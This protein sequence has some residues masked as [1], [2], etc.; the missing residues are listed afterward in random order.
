MVNDITVNKF[1][2]HTHLHISQVLKI[3]RS[4]VQLSTLLQLQLQRKRRYAYGM[5]IRNQIITTSWIKL[6][7]ELN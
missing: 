4:F 7:N 2:H 3:Y 5:E 6:K 1:V